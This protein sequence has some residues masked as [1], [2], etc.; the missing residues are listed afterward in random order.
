MESWDHANGT[1]L[2]DPLRDGWRDLHAIAR[3]ALDLLSIQFDAD[4]TE[5]FG[6]DPALEHMILVRPGLSL[7][8]RDTEA[9]PL[10]VAFTEHGLYVRFGQ[11]CTREFPATASETIENFTAERDRFAWRVVQ[12][13]EG[14]FRE[15]SALVQPGLIVRQHEFSSLDGT[16]VGGECKVRSGGDEPAGTETVLRWQAWSPRAG[17]AASG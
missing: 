10:A 9:A 11:W 7:T 15:S 4:L 8:P 17:T 12:L 16:R 5:G 3:R 14:R 13:V 1:R 2:A 6:D